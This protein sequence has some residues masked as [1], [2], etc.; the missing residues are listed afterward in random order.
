MITSVIADGDTLSL[1]STM[2][3]CSYLLS[4]VPV[5][6][7]NPASTITFRPF[8]PSRYQNILHTDTLSVDDFPA[9]I[10]RTGTE[11][12]SLNLRA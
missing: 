12:G 6:S 9:A 7:I 10:S 11:P 4:P 2:S 1:F 3:G 8:E 5:V